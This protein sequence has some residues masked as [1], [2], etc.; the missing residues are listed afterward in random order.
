LR[1]AAARS[2]CG[3]P[4][5]A[6]RL[7]QAM[8]RAMGGRLPFGSRA[9]A[10]R[11]ATGRDRACNIRTSGSSLGRG[12]NRGRYRPCRRHTRTAR[13][14]SA[15]HE[16]AR[17]ARFSAPSE[18]RPNV[19]IADPSGPLASWFPPSG[20]PPARTPVRDMTPSK[21][22]SASASTRPKCTPRARQASSE[23]SRNRGV[24]GGGGNPI[25]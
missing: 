5:T 22:L 25:G 17:S 18:A 12:C 15:R 23:G 14:S 19:Q 9:T 21:P 11:C 10:L 7:P 6:R 8:G 13:T 24:G 1:R 3:L 16:V 4:T 2:G 20:K